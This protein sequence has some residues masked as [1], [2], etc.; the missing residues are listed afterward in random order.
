MRV[1]RVRASC[2][3]GLFHYRCYGCMRWS[4]LRMRHLCYGCVRGTSVTC[5]S[6]APSHARPRPQ[7]R[8]RVASFAPLPPAGCASCRLATVLNNTPE[9]NQWRPDTAVTEVS[10]FG[11]LPVLRCC[12]L[13]TV[14]ASSQRRAAERQR[15]RSP[16][17][18]RDQDRTFGQTDATRSYDGMS[19][20]SVSQDTQSSCVSPPAPRR[21]SLRQPAREAST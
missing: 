17:D 10:H 14:Q 6:T 11:L 5:D 18:C 19:N 7:P 4:T 15:S 13:D 21:P 16:R 3:P 12:R 20:G 8:P 2:R 9:S 1:T